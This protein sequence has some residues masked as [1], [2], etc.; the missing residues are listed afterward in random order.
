MDL[1]GPLLVLVVPF[2][3]LLLGVWLLIVL[4]SRAE[5][6][7]GL[8][9]TPSSRGGRARAR[10]MTILVQKLVRRTPAPRSDPV[11]LPSEHCHCHLTATGLPR[12]RRVAVLTCRRRRPRDPPGAVSEILKN[13]IGSCLAEPL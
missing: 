12:Q 3:A 8:P 9:R 4:I 1:I 6:G 10:V 7:D 2:V 13:K 11:T 5:D